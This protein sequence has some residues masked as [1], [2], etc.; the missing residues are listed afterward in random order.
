MKKLLFLA[1]AA[2]CVTACSKD[3]DA[4]NNCPQ[5][6]SIIIEQL[7]STSV[8]FS[9]GIET[10]TAW[11][12]EY[13]LVNFTLGTGTIARTSQEDFFIEGLQPE[14]NYRIYIRTNCGSDGFSE[15]ISVDITTPSISA[16]CNAPSNLQLV[17]LTDSSIELSWDENDETAWEVE[18]GPVGFVPGTGLVIST[19]QNSYNI[20]G[21]NS[22]ATYEIYVRA[23]CG[24]EGYSEYSEALVITTD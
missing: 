18:Y 15:Y 10:E 16:R 20:E 14:T 19:S 6:G 23:N 24:S 22:G 1:I 5:P 13:G 12:I 8:L 21:L 3:D 7:N 11:E 4:N 2:L 9:W 17:S